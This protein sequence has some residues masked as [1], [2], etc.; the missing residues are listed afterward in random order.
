MIRLTVIFGLIAI[1]GCTSA[2]AW[3]YSVRTIEGNS[4]QVSADDLSQAY[5]VL[6]GEKN[7]ANVRYT[8]GDGSVTIVNPQVRYRGEMYPVSYYSSY[9]VCMIFALGELQVAEDGETA[10]KAVYL[11]NGKIKGVKESV[12]S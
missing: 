2:F 4:V 11:E 9:S 10:S 12:T 7:A 5:S 1:L 8:N 3:N 6:I